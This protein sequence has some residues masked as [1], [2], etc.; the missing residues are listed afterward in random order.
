MQY[1]GESVHVIF[2]EAVSVSKGKTLFND[3]NESGNS[4]IV[5][6]R[7][8]KEHNDIVSLG[9]ESKTRY[10]ASGDLQNKVTPLD[11]EP[12]FGVRNYQTIKIDVLVGNDSSSS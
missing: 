6:K 12:P 2:D 4:I 3:D 9:Q 8:H 5:P 11:L 7:S 10:A 1:V